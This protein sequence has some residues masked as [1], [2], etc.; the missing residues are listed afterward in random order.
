[1]HLTDVASCLVEH[2]FCL[3]VFQI[4]N[5]TLRVILLSRTVPHQWDFW[6]VRV[7]HRQ[8]QLHQRPHLSEPECDSREVDPHH[9]GRVTQPWPQHGCPQLYQ[10]CSSGKF[11]FLGVGGVSS[12][13]TDVNAARSGNR[14][15]R[16][17]ELTGILFNKYRRQTFRQQCLLLSP[18]HFKTWFQYVRLYTAATTNCSSKSITWQEMITNCTKK[19]VKKTPHQYCPRCPFSGWV[20][21]WRRRSGRATHWWAW[22]RLP[23]AWTSPSTSFPRKRSSCLGKLFTH[24][25]QV[26]LQ[27]ACAVNRLLWE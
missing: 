8:P 18:W 17:V 22:N 23:T 7:C 12:A 9:R 5:I 1:M 14:S 25:A 24:N 2:Q 16:K 6:C 27:S 13:V 11:I 26:L 10:N 21:F 19:T 3:C 20:S 15:S 4:T